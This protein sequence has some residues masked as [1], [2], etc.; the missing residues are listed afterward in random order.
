MEFSPIQNLEN[1][2]PNHLESLWPIQWILYLH[3][4]IPSAEVWHDST[5]SVTV[6]G[7]WAGACGLWAH[8]T[9]QTDWVSCRPGGG[10]SRLVEGGRWPALFSCW[11]Q[12][13]QVW[14][15]LGEVQTVSWLGL[16]YKKLLILSS[17]LAFLITGG[18]S[19]CPRI[20]RWVGSTPGP[21][22]RLRACRLT[23]GGD[24]GLAWPQ[25]H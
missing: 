11:H 14:T 15:K 17:W 1:T 18:K 21:A 20:S 5:G 8:R 6:L 22:Q 23:P 4:Q 24:A 10:A 19:V 13:Q 2:Q 25:S 12:S 7:L 9:M 3:L 16:R